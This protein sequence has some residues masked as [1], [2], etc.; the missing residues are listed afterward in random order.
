[1]DM[2]KIVKVKFKWLMFRRHCC[3]SWGAT[4]RF[5]NTVGSELLDW[6]LCKCLE[7]RVERNPSQTARRKDA[8]II[9]GHHPMHIYWVLC[10]Q[11]SRH[12]GYSREKPDKCMSG[13]HFRQKKKK[14]R[15]LKNQ[16]K[17]G[18]GRE[19]RMYNLRGGDLSEGRRKE[20]TRPLSAGRAAQAE[21]EKPK[22]MA[23][24][25]GPAGG[26]SPVR[27][28]PTSQEE[29]GRRWGQRGSKGP[30]YEGPCKPSEGL[31][32]YS[33]CDGKPEECSEQG[34]TGCVEGESRSRDWVRKPPQPWNE[35]RWQPG[36]DGS[37][38]DVR[39]G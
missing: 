31:G 23:E 6:W 34:G 19:R 9:A 32:W 38:R 7:N 10:N 18:K 35:N 15:Y 33:K 36:L 12:T 3:K 26:K 4:S 27:L 11:C 25:A 2:T 5:N 29:S 8:V 13:L 14:R 21:G 37:G 28:E 24:C 30:C 17:P 39:N 16:R 20:W 22:A 1:M